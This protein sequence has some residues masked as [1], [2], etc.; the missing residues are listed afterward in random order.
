MKED[1][2]R[3]KEQVEVNRNDEEVQDR[4]L[5]SKLESKTKASE[6]TKYNLPKVV[7]MKKLPEG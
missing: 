1:A 3:L 6:S 5:A 2:L 4:M 7:K